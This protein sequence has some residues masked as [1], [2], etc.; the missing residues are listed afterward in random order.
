MFEQR[1]CIRSWWSSPKKWIEL[2][3]DCDL[4]ELLN[5]VCFVDFVVLK[6]LFVTL[7]VYISLDQQSPT[8]VVKGRC[9]ATFRCHSAS[10]LL[11]SILAYSSLQLDCR[12]LRQFQVCGTREMSKSCR[13]LYISINACKGKWFWGFTWYYELQ[14]FNIKLKCEK[15]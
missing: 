10:A 7:T 14:N 2:K 6:S 13:P 15:D 9:P 4:N 11:A 8:P 3:L 5:Q 1:N 12:K